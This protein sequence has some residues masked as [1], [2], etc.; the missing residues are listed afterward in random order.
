MNLA[1]EFLNLITD[2]ANTLGRE[3]SV[4]LQELREYA[5]ERMLHLSTIVGEPGY[6][7]AVRA[8]RDNVALKAGLVLTEQADQYDSILVGTIGGALGIAAKAIAAG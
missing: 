7:E 2:E 3:L 6:M 5:A 8:E 1:D 4:D